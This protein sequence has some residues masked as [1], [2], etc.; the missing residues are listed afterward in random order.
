MRFN[1]KLIHA[2][3]DSDEN[4]EGS[5]TVPIYR[6]TAY[7]FNN[8]EHAANPVSYTHLTLPTKRIV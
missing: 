7:Q 6:T 4:S 8:T 5:I 2:G 1:S 3:W